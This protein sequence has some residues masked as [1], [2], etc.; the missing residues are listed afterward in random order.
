M[1]IPHPLGPI[2]QPPKPTSPPASR[3]AAH[4]W[5]DAMTANPRSS[6][7][8]RR[9]KVLARLRALDDP[10]WICGLPIDASLPAGH[11]MAMEA[12]ELIPVSKG[13]SATDLT[14]I[15]RAHR[16][17]NNWRRTKSVGVVNKIRSN[18]L[19]HSTYSNP[20]EFIELAK[21]RGD[22]EQD[23]LMSPMPTTTDW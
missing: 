12:D 7:G 1:S 4:H 3:I 5:T 18:V 15:A 9:R 11:P 8:H 13:G 16:C 6:N 10:C 20:L 23:H 2:P 17:C 14:N 21:T 22:S 19:S